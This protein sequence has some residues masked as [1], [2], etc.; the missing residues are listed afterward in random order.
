MNEKITNSITQ[1]N[2]LVNLPVKLKEKVKKTLAT[3]KE[4]VE[5]TSKFVEVVISDMKKPG[6]QGVQDKLEQ[7]ALTA[8]VVATTQ[9]VP[10]NI[11]TV[12]KTTLEYIP[13]IKKLNQF[14]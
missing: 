5:I 3:I 10:K 7:V 11:V 1:I 13:K 9:S 14:F 4:Y 12:A 6:V 8:N 2:N